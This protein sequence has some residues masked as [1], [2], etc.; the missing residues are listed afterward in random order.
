MPMHPDCL[1]LIFS[2][3]FFLAKLVK[4]S[5]Q[6]SLLQGTVLM[7]GLYTTFFF[8]FIRP[9]AHAISGKGYV[10]LM[11]RRTTM[12]RASKAKNPDIYMVTLIESLIVSLAVVVIAFAFQTPDLSQAEWE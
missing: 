4:L 9:I 6:D 5:A 10:P 11:N 1:A 3:I 7:S 12:R 8:G 2:L